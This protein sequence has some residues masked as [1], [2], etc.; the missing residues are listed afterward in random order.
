MLTS[1]IGLIGCPMPLIMAGREVPD[2]ALL[3]LSSPSLVAL[4]GLCLTGL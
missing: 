4:M 3:F 2:T 1:F